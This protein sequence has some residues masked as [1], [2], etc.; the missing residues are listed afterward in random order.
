[1]EKWETRFVAKAIVRC[2][3]EECKDAV[4][5][6]GVCLREKLTGRRVQ[7]T[8]NDRGEDLHVRGFLNQVSSGRQS[9]PGLFSTNDMGDYV[10]VSGNV[11]FRSDLLIEFAYDDDLAY[12]IH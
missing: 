12:L 5:R 9:W 7:I 3:L 4:G 1:M 6:P 10:F 8:T 2:Y 11:A